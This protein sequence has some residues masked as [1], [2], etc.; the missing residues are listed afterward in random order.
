MDV[1]LASDLRRVGGDVLEWGSLREE[2]WFISCPE[3]IVARLFCDSMEDNEAIV[4]EGVLQYSEFEGSGETFKCLGPM[5]LDAFKGPHTVICMDAMNF[6]CNLHHNQFSP[7]YVLRELIKAYAGFK[8]AKSCTIATGNWGG[9]CFQVN[10]LCYDVLFLYFVIFLLLQIMYANN[11]K[12]KSCF[13]QGNP[14][15][16][17]KIQNIAASQANKALFYYP[18]NDTQLETKIE[19]EV[20]LDETC[21]VGK[22]KY[23]DSYLVIIYTWFAILRWSLQKELLQWCSTQATSTPNK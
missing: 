4:V 5:N 13:T 22:L 7:V 2:M 8:S 18:F 17:G 1:N 14:V 19:T 16:K 3:L 6:N 9:G 15:L 20:Q 10:D 23:I 12:K 21:S 11:V